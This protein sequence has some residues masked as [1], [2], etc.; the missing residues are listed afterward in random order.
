MKITFFTIFNLKINFSLYFTHKMIN[1]QFSR[2]YSHYDIMVRS[3]INGW[4]L[5][6]YQWKED[7]HTY[8]LN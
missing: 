2:A 3:Y 1:S 4:V 6:W 5:F 8:T 7:V